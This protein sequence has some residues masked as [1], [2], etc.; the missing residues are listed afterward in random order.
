LIDEAA[1]S[2]EIAEKI[3]FSHVTDIENLTVWEMT[4][5]HIKYDL[6]VSDQETYDDEDNYERLVNAVHDKV[7]NAVVGISWD[8][9]RTWQW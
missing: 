8:G 2:T 6:D 5:D 1:L 9:G 4:S 7:D 3:I